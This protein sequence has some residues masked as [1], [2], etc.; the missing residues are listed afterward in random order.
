MS[1]AVN[2]SVEVALSIVGL[3]CLIWVT[4]RALRRSE[5][6]AKILFKWGL[7]IPFV[8]FC[9][10][11]AH[12]LGAFGPFVI[13]FMGII[14]SVVWTP[15]ISEWFSRPLTSLYDGG[16]EP[17]EPKPYYSVAQARRQRRQFLQAV[18]AIREQLAK[19]PHDFEGVMLLAAIQAED[20]QDLPSAEITLNHFC[21]Q[22]NPPPKQFA[23]A[24]NQLADWHIKRTQDFDSA[25]IALEK[26]GARFPDTELS[27]QAAQRIA[28]LGGTEKVVLASLDRQPMP[29]PEGVKSMGLLAST[30][31]MRPTE[32]DPTKLAAAY[33]KHLEQHPLDTEAR[34]K[35]AVIY[36]EHY[37]R[38]DLAGGELNQ[39]IET[40]NQPA[41]RV[42]HWLNLLADLQ[43]QHGADYETVRET[44]ERIIE[45][46]PD[47]AAGELARARLSRLKLELKGRTEKPGVK[48][49][50]YEQNIG[51]KSGSPRQ[52]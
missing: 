49:G 20:L 13:A 4:I 19:F 52:L 45:R 2:L 22:P 50:V 33:V 29:V 38:L 26:I 41:K 3:A 47:F 36:A 37:Q 17:P 31:H 25:R 9:I 23:A 14:L 51:L 24:M 18:V 6:P 21:D 12:R 46:F 8:I 16:N 10:W 28:H 40:P 7:T 15:H 27:L 32:A 43:V 1:H 39:L 11:L 48:L 35:L 42:A 34:E 5:D 30:E 44:L